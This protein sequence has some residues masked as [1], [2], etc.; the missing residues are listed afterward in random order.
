M[1][2][3]VQLGPD[4]TPLSSVADP[5]RSYRLVVTVRDRG[6]PERLA[7]ADLTIAVNCSAAAAKMYVDRSHPSTSGASRLGAVDADPIDD[8]QVE[9]SDAP[10]TPPSSSLVGALFF[11]SSHR[12]VVLATVISVA[13]F[14]IIVIVAAVGIT[15]VVCRWRRRRRRKLTDR[16]RDE[17]LRQQASTACSDAGCSCAERRSTASNRSCVGANRVLHH[18]DSASLA[19]SS[20]ATSSMRGGG[21]MTVLVPQSTSTSLS[22]AGPWTAVI[23]TGSGTE[24]DDDSE[25]DDVPLSSGLMTS[26]SSS[27]H[28]CRCDGDRTQVTVRFLCKLLMTSIFVDGRMEVLI[29][30][31]LR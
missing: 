15:V 5:M 17:W 6:T 12:V 30:V 13:L 10:S 16:R 3:T 29:S 8:I 4:G 28:A 25:N 20:I 11:N 26:S 27:H 2:L 9:S 7:V 21:R 19:G 18:H 31:A 23:D 1:H 14:L 22:R 24:R